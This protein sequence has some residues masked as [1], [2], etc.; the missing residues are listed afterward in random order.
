M[1][2]TIKQSRRG[3]QQ[4]D[5]QADDKEGRDNNDNTKWLREGEEKGWRLGNVN[6][7]PK[8]DGADSQVKA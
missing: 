4:T 8:V 5:G 1:D 6:K 2:P 7:M 3:E